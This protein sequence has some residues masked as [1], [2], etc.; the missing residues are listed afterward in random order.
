MLKFKNL[1]NISEQLEKS[2]PEMPNEVVFQMLNGIQNMD[3]DPAEKEKRPML[4]GKTQLDTYI[5]ITDPFTKKQVAIGA[6]MEV[7]GDIV[8]SY[9]PFLAGLNTDIFNGKFSLSSSSSIDREL[10]EVFWLSP[11]RDGSPCEDSRVPKLFRIIDYKEDSKKQLSKIETLRSA[12]EL[13]KEVEKSEE[14]IREIAVSQNIN[15]TDPDSIKTKVAQ[16][17]SS[18]PDKFLQV[19]KDPK[20]KTKSVIKK[21]FDAGILSYEHTTRLVSLNG[22]ELFTLSKDDMK[23]VNSAVVN[24]IDTARNGKSIFEGITK[25]LDKP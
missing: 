24:W 14:S 12:L 19:A 8:K 10:Y 21:A 11:Q 18:F 17:A 16:F 1:N 4:Y 6:P 3:F 7:D 20:T 25:Q 23:D 15:E 22:N 13:L 2:I 5:K 9:R